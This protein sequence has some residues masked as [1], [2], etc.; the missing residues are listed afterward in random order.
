MSGAIFPLSSLILRWTACEHVVSLSSLSISSPRGLLL[1]VF[2]RWISFL[3]M[4]KRIC[5]RCRSRLSST[6]PHTRCDRCIEFAGGVPCTPE[7]TCDECR[8]FT[9]EQWE[10]LRLAR[11]NVREMK[12]TSV[13]SLSLLS[14]EQRNCLL[15]DRL[16]QRCCRKWNRWTLVIPFLLPSRRFPLQAE[17]PP[18]VRGLRRSLQRRVRCLL[19][20]Q[21]NLNDDLPPGR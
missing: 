18:R 7:S 10:L 2:S 1:L 13:P 11:L 4:P 5:D 20:S 16:L 8:H 15:M 19:L 17:F 9:A 6:N 14:P 3:T 21:P 12:G